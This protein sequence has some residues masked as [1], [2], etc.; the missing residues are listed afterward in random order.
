M[1]KVLIVDDGDDDRA[2]LSF[3]LEKHGLSVHCASNGEEAAWML[4]M[5]SPALII[6]DYAM[7]GMSGSELVRMIASMP[8]LKDV[9]VIMVSGAAEEEVV[10]AAEPIKVIAFLPKGTAWPVLRDIVDKC[11]SVRGELQGQALDPSARMTR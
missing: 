8:H 7:P 5:L 11:L 3:Q 2:L 1:P 10:R 9:A 6:T 4:S